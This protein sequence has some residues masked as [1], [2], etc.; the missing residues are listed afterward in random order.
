MSFKIEKSI[1]EKGL[2][3]L[4]SEQNVVSLTKLPKQYEWLEEIDMLKGQVFI[5]KVYH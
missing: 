1:F 3:I 2:I 4:S 5:E